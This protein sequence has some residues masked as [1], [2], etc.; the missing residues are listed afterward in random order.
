MGISWFVVR[1]Q[2]NKL[3]KQ[4]KAWC[5]VLCGC[6]AGAKQTKQGLGLSYN[7]RFGVWCW[8]I[9]QP[10]FSL[11]LGLVLREKIRSKE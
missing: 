1:C 5:L 9:L 4:A 10:S 11:V 8:F 3:S 2:A 7:Q 6:C